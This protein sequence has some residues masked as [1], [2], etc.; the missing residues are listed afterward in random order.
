MCACAR[1]S[2]CIYVYIYLYVCV[3]ESFFHYYPQRTTSCTARSEFDL[4]TE[5]RV[6]PISSFLPCR[7]LSP[8]ELLAR[9]RE[10]FSRRQVQNRQAYQHLCLWTD[11]D[12]RSTCPSVPYHR[13][14][15]RTLVRT[16]ISTPGL[17]VCVLPLL[18]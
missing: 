7:E 1:A 13:I 9:A 2:A 10:P 11:T 18:I 6:R 15:V 16:N 5:H 8:G 17:R 3:C 14:A 4:S 12:R